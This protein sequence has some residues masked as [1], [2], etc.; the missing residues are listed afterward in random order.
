MLYRIR[1]ESLLLSLV[2]M[3]VLLWIESLGLSVHCL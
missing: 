1:Y 2:L 3:L